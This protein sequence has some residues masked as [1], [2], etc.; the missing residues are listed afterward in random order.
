MGPLVT[1]FFNFLA[2][3]CMCHGGSCFPDQGS[4]TPPAMEARNLNHWT[5]REV[6]SVLILIIGFCLC[7]RDYFSKIVVFSFLNDNLFLLKNLDIFICGV[8]TH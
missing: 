8:F 1:F 2:T 4:N 5:T 7:S 3:P 6:P